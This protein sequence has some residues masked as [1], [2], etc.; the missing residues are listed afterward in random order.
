MREQKNNA[1]RRMDKEKEG[2]EGSLS[3]SLNGFLY[4]RAASEEG[5]ESE[6]ERETAFFLSP[7]FFERKKK[8]R[9]KTR[10]EKKTIFS[11]FFFLF[12]FLSLIRPV[13]PLGP[14]RHGDA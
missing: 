4:D 13:P 14:P 9:K 10:I 8:E 3:L 11:L 2:R 7:F 12:L 5:G 6:R 1:E